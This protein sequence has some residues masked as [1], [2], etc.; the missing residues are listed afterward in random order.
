MR[1][2]RR[3]LMACLLAFSLVSGSVA[4]AA[5]RATEAE[6]AESY[7]Y[8][9]Y[10]DSQEFEVT[11]EQYGIIYSLQNDREPLLE[12]LRTVLGDRM[13]DYFQIIGGRFMG[14]DSPSDGVTP[15]QPDGQTEPEFLISGTKL[16]SYNGTASVVT[17]PDNVTEIGSMAFRN[18]SNVRAVIL[19]ESVKTIRQCAFYNCLH[20]TYIVIPKSVSA[21][22][23]NFVYGCEKLTNFVTPKKS[24]ADSYAAENDIPTATDTKVQPLRK[25]CYLLVGDSDKNILLNCLS[26]VK[27]K[28]SRKKVATVTAGG[29]IKAKKAGRAV[30]TATADGRKY[31][32]QVIVWKKTEKKRLNQIVRSSVEAG[33][34]RYEKIRAVHNWF[35]RNV[36][37]DYYRYQFGRVPAVSHKAE[38]ALLKK[39]AVCDGYA[40]AF[41]MVMKKLKIPCR[42]VVGG[43]S[44]VGHGWNMVKLGGK[45]YHIDVTFD[46]PIVND[47][48]KNTKPYYTYF[49][50][51]SSVM[52]KTHK[53]KKSKYPKCNSKKYN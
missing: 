27:W 19:P 6:A 45:W 35:I 48:N 3:R 30:L 21:L 52:K 37:Y 13:P 25:K 36:K 40:H 8:F 4:G 41:Q 22:S 7:R 24:S 47:S 10:L 29:K 31:T 14:V 16:L 33:M 51:S 28:S 46:D 32:C 38:G 23:K 9:I 53:W 39:V 2:M 20:L 43:S 44:G 1:K 34:S 17:V 12:Y 5:L 18:N 49:L 15:A 26:K 50:K 11:Q 42:F